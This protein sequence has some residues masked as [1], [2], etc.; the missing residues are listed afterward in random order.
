VKEVLA[1]GADAILLLGVLDVDYVRACMNTDLPVVLVDQAEDALAVDTVVCDNPAAARCVVSHLMALGH[2]RIAYAATAKTS[3]SDFDNLERRVVFAQVL[4][5]A[6]L[7][8]AVPDGAFVSTQPEPADPAVDAFVARLRRRRTAP[9]A[10]V[11]DSESTLQCLMSCAQRAG[12]RVPA[13]LSLATLAMPP[14]EWAGTG[15]PLT[16]C[17]V[18]FAG[19]GGTAVK[20]LEARSRSLAMPS[21][22][23]RASFTFW[24]GQT[25]AAPAAAAAPM[26]RTRRKHPGDGDAGTT[27]DR[28]EPAA[29]LAHA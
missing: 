27:P 13:D 17:C 4:A 24:P 25:A 6:G 14:D 22:L 21:R 10:I 15:G 23:I 26:Q 28:A 9:T 1:S 18:D 16:G 3:W 29:R 2:R 19:M 5:E 7:A 12:L 20:A 8:P 11:T